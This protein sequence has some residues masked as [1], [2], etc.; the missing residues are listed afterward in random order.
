LI[1][2]VVCTAC[3]LWGATALR[4][5]VFDF[6]YSG[7]WFGNT[8]NGSGTLTATQVIPGIYTITSISGTQNGIGFSMTGTGNSLV[9]SGGTGTGTFDLMIQGLGLDVLT[10]AGSLY[11]ETGATGTNLGTNF[12]IVDPVPEVSTVSLL[13]AMGLGVWLLVRKFPSRKRARS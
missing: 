8:V 13:S 10:F 12:R 2:K 9:Y 3:L 5:D 4:A 1:R 11:T 7:N 6:S